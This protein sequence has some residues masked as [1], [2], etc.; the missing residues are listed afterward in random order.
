M[1]PKLI[2]CLALVLSGGLFFLSATQPVYGYEVLIQLNHTNLNTDYSF[3]R[4]TAVRNHSTNNEM[5]FFTVIAMPKDKHQPENFTGLLMI[6]DSH[7]NKPDD[8]ITQTSVRARKWPAGRDLEAVPKPLRSKC[9]AFQFLVA[10][11]YL[12]TSEFMVEET[13]Y[14]Y[15]SP[16]GYCFNL[17]EFAEEK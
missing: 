8:F 16:T 9:I 10:A 3:L 2:L 7:L 4:V 5:V 1:K 6:R 14:K 15:G 17:K 11:K 12:E 13:P